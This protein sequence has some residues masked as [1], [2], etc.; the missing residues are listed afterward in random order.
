[1]PKTQPKCTPA[2]PLRSGSNA[3]GFVDNQISTSSVV[4]TEKGNNIQYTPKQIEAYIKKMDNAGFYAYGP[5]NWYF[6]AVQIIRQLQEEVKTAGH[7][8][9]EQ[10]YE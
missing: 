6:D 8:D 4:G 3:A 1:M 10:F 7:H 9:V 5:G 2:E